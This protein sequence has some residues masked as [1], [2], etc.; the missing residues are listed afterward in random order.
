MPAD[1]TSSGPAV[2]S[3]RWRR[4]PASRARSDDLLELTHALRA[5]LLARGEFLPPRWVEESANDLKLGTLRG[6]VLLDGNSPVGFAFFSPRAARAYGHVHVLPG[7][8][9]LDRAE[10]LL[11]GLRLEQSPPSARLDVGVTGLTPEEEEG[12]RGRRVPP[13]AETIVTRYALDAAL[14]FLTA[15]NRPE[16]WA[17]A[18]IRE[19]P[20]AALA[21]LDWAAYQGTPDQ[22]LAADTP[23]ADARVLDEILRGLLGRFVDEAST[24]LTDPS[25]APVGILLTAEQTPRRAIFLDLAVRPDLR[26]RGLGGFLLRWG[27]R[28]LTALGYESV[29]LWV[30]ESNAPAR[31]L[32]DRLGFVLAG[33]AVIVRY[34]GPPGTPQPQRSR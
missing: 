1:L 20:L 18:P 10:A 34:P 26:G 2:G 23:E 22:S 9:G 32:Y 17:Q 16:G 24:A 29:R 21:E 19:L 4:V 25:G 7:P 30:T 27:M 14:P 8:G 12:L 33:R 11:E 28:A 6:W 13:R 15:A 3:D 5:E 31:R